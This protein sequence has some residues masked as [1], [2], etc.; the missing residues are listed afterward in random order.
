M[1]F[2]VG[3]ASYVNAMG[4]VN[5]FAGYRHDNIDLKHRYPESHPDFKAHTKFKNIDIFQIGI[6]ARSTIG[7]NFYA[8]A[9]ASW[10]WI[11]DGDL[12]QTAS[13][14]HN[15]THWNNASNGSCDLWQPKCH[16]NTFDEKYV[17]DANIA[18]GYPFYFC[19]CSAIVAPVIG[20]AVDAQDISI[21][22]NGFQ[23]TRNECSW[24]DI[25]SGSD[26]CR[27]TFF[28]RWYGP[29]VGVDFAYRPCNECFSLYAAF[30]YH[31]GTFKAKRSH[32][33]ND[34]ESHERHG[35][36][37]GWVV[38]L[39]ADY[40][41]SGCWTVGLYLKFTD[42]SASKHSRWDNGDD[43]SSNSRRKGKNSESW[44]SYAVNVEIG[45]Q[46]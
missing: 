8:R 39:G 24:V 46:F 34:F 9:E 27:H 15:A 10:G 35:D 11:L 7:C 30:E 13:I 26:C 38:D 19:D 31:W 14:S 41:F 3:S 18:I 29:F 43:S 36:M 28:N 4:D 25:E 16:E 5:L 2:L 32:H 6:N 45:R 44:N 17:Y 42:F 22:D 20:Y 12:K 23:I 21:D 40:E 33:S 37:D 1:T